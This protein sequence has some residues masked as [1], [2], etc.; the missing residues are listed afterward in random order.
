M[1]IPNFFSFPHRSL[2]LETMITNANLVSPS[3][4]HETKDESKNL[5][6]WVK[7]EVYPALEE[8]NGGNAVQALEPAVTHYI[9]TASSADD[10]L[11]LWSIG[12]KQGQ[13]LATKD[14]SVSREHL[15]IYAAATSDQ[16]VVRN[17]GKL[18]SYFVQE[19]KVIPKDHLHP[20]KDGDNDDDSSV[21]TVDEEDPV[22]TQSSPAVDVPLSRVAKH[23]ATPQTKQRLQII[24]LDESITLPFFTSHELT[25]G[26][27]EGDSSGSLSPSSRW[28]LQCGKLGTTIVLSRI[29]ICFVAS[30]TKAKN[31][32]RS[33]H[34]ALTN[35]GAR[36]AETFSSEKCCKNYLLT[37]SYGVKSKHIMAW[38]L[39]A[40]VVP[41]S[42]L[43]TF[44]SYHANSMD[45][46]QAPWPPEN[47]VPTLSPP[48]H[49]S[50]V[51][52][53]PHLWKDGT[54]LSFQEIPSSAP[55][56][57]VVE[58]VV[59]AGAQRIL[60]HS[61]DDMAPLFLT[62]MDLTIDDTRR[63][64]HTFWADHKKK[65]P[66]SF[67]LDTNF[68]KSQYR[69][70]AQ[71]FDEIGI[72]S[73]TGKIIGNAVTQQQKLEDLL[74]PPLVDASIS[75]P[76]TPVTERFGSSSVRSSTQHSGRRSSEEEDALPNDTTDFEINHDSLTGPL[77]VAQDLNLSMLDKTDESIA[78]DSPD[79]HF[80]GDSRQCDSIPKAR[81][82]GTTLEAKTRRQKRSVPEGW[83]TAFPQGLH[84]NRSKGT[85]EG[86]AMTHEPAITQTVL[87]LI[88]LKSA[89]TC[90][91]QASTRNETNF[92]AFRKNVVPPVLAVGVPLQYDRSSSS[93]AS[94]SYHGDLD[95]QREQMEAQQ[96]RA[97]ELFR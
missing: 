72:P 64:V 77:S 78:Q 24:N 14:R 33:K 20:K 86:D 85:N 84:R 11:L 42:F 32:L 51:P 37:D 12:R 53:D 94:S 43:D 15:R 44:L 97:D 22:L 7:I 75:T 16:I 73:L 23:I 74:P 46:L 45:P 5:G 25:S 35:T 49:W 58:L 10:G 29:D 68:S 87:G 27:L 62:P 83:M 19:E 79:D 13:Y 67:V 90:P 55:D 96:R 41:V 48:S 71:V 4:V 88:T 2:S 31:A 92:K 54:L 91:R 38:C 3:S 60:L 26:S 1:M 40:T 52:P 59:A 6:M 81:D 36:Y 30:C 56:A 82:V 21:T 9:R 8:A 76:A 39:R 17:L 34:K 50:P 70:V 28:V 18:G 66:Y 69:M 93:K 57:E 47:I 65:H 95:I 80:V 89:F 63:I 61:I